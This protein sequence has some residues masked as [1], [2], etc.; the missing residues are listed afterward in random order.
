MA[1]PA[2][3]MRGWTARWGPESVLALFAALV[4]LGFLGSVDLWGKREQRAS[5]EAID[6]IDHGHWLVAQIQCRPRLEKPPLPRWTIAG[7]M[8][9]T[10][11]RDEWM[12]RFPSALAALATVGLVY[13]LGRR[14][15]DR[16]VALASGLALTSLGF[17]I[18]ELR[19]A[20]NDGPLA[21]FTTLALYA[22][23]RRLHAEGAEPG[24]RRWSMVFYLALGLGFLT[25]GPIILLLAGLTVV[26]YLVCV[27]KLRVGLA[28]LWDGWGLLLFVVLA[29]SWPV[30]VLL[31]DPNAARVWWLEMGQKAGMAGVTHHRQRLPLAAD[32]T[33]MTL[34]WVVLATTAVLLPLMP[35]GR[36]TR[37]RIWFPWWWAVGNLVMFCFW[38]VAKPNY[39]LPCLPAAA[40]LIGFEWVRLTRLARVPDA[41]HATLARRLLQMH[42]VLL[43]A[44]SVVAPVFVRRL[45]PE[46]LGPCV[47]VSL[48]VA[49]AVLLSAWAWRRGADALALAPLTGAVA[50]AV[51]AGY[52]ALAPAL[53]PVHSH[54]TL[55][56]TLDRLLPPET[57]TVMF[58][59][60][61]DEGLWFYLRG[62][63]LVPVPGSLPKYNGAMT[64]LEEV[65]SNRLE[66][67]WT[68]RA[69][70]EKNL[71][72]D[73]I[74]RPDRASSYVLIR[75]KDYEK[76]AAGLAPYVTPI[77]CEEGMQRNE[78][79]LLR[80]NPPGPVARDPERVNPVRR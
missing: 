24:A 32:W 62:R 3:G 29:L 63:A 50:V 26:P 72:V 69:E 67:D 8:R 55:A 17:F 47:V 53:N 40:L 49:V 25:K 21:C 79:V 77:L 74:Q 48:A 31:A 39:F 20:G 52:G 4:F 57:R 22:A 70:S 9:L 45:A 68:K 43:F 2:V 1:V 41:Q 61:L 30:P 5:A 76:Y 42:W 13:A 33:W 58:F 38:S 36:E 75:A 44:A 18:S 37:P 6:T 73:W 59:K 71:F 56:A 28:R 23:W 65:R 60:E 35:H 34:P 10:G 12:V 19:Q 7:L 51:L 54:R 11:R 66:V 16:D 27:G 46:F 78:L 80:V 64:L 14:L 15:A